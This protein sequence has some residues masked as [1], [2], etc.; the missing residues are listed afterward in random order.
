[1]VCV[2]KRRT[3]LD[4]S[5]VVCLAMAAVIAL[6][7]KILRA[8]AASLANPM[9]SADAK[10]LILFREQIR[11]LKAH[12]RRHVC[13]PAWWTKTVGGCPRTYP[14][15]CQRYRPGDL[16]WVAEPLLSL[17]DQR[18]SESALYYYA[19]LLG[20]KAPIPHGAAPKRFAH[21]EIPAYQMERKY[22]RFTLKLSS[23]QLCRAHSLG[24]HE[25]QAESDAMT[26]DTPER[27]WT[28]SYGSR[29]GAWS[30]NPEIV[31]I[32]FAAKYESIEGRA[33]PALLQIGGMPIA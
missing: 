28:R 18:G 23:V 4:K 9:V 22:S 12:T 20:T 32:G 31:S 26:T 3:A 33:L 19:D 8:A 15:A 25:I 2:E 7:H 6:A 27:W 16:C 14:T 30:D 5:F 13:L 21:N 11:G 29:L 24:Q 1:M 17:F 10:H